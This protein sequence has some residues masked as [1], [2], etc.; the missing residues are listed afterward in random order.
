MIDTSKVLVY[1]NEFG[2]VTVVHPAPKHEGAQCPGTSFEEKVGR[3]PV[4]DESDMRTPKNHRFDIFRTP[5]K[6]QS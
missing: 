3:L 4:E 1:N 2:T 5:K 6:L